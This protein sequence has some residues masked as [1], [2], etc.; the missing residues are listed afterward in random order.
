MVEQ[1]SYRQQQAQATR[2]RIVDAA[3]S[4]M[5]T[6][7]WSATTIN[8]IAAEAGVAVQTIYGAFG[9]KRALL[10]GMREAMMRDSSI[11][12]LMDQA[13]VEPDS[14]ERLR[15][16]AR[17]IRQQMET[18]YDVIAIH[19]EAARAEVEVAHAY[20]KVL[21]GRAKTFRAFVVGFEADLVVDLSTAAD[22]LWAFSN[23]ELWR[24]LVEER[25]WSPDR[26]ES[27]L[28]DTL[29]AQLVRPTARPQRSRGTTA[30]PGG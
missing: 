2:R 22:I 5:G 11:P 18:S 13:A 17:L 1:Q 26:Y 19:R 8:A 29:I 12:A 27:W 14:A 7:G 24:E 25:R 3:R 9:N 6:H 28:A 15:I 10:D 20:R 21:D 23:E 16:W 30:R 4:L